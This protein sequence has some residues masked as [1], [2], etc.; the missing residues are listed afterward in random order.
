VPGAEAE[1]EV[2]GGVDLLE[3][4][5]RQGGDPAQQA[6]PVDGLEL[7]E[8][9]HAATGQPVGRAELHLG[10]NPLIVVVAGA[11]VAMVR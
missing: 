2:D 3:A 11:T 8:V 9:D 4:L 7:V 6:A 5:R 10:G 1:R